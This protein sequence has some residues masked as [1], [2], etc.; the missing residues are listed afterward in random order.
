MSARYSY[1]TP[2][3]LLMTFLLFWA[4]NVSMI[5]R[6]WADMTLDKNDILIEDRYSYVFMATDEELAKQR[7]GFTL[8]NGMIV[9]ISLDRIVSLNGIET[10]FPSIEFPVGG[11]VIQNG[12][13]NSTQDSA[14]SILSFVVQNSLDDQV[15]KNINQINIEISN[16]PKFD[17]KSGAVIS[18]LILPTLQ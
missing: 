5:D 7:G 6:V 15:I 2:K 10:V 4:V 8:P 12:I 11:V 18:D 17:F 9:N 14:G 1:I 16:I 3:K 13:V